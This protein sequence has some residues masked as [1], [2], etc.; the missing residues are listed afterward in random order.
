MGDLIEKVKECKSYSSVG[1]L[2]GYYYYNA[3]VKKN[4]IKF[5]NKHGIDIEKQISD[6]KNRKTYCLYCGKELHGENRLTRKFCNSSCAASYNNSL[7]PQKTEEERN[8]IS[9]GLIEFYKTHKRIVKTNS[10]IYKTEGK[11]ISDCIKDGLVLNPYD[12]SFKDKIICEK[13]YSEKTCIICGNKFKPFLNT[14][15]HLY[16]GNTCS[17]KCH[18]ILISQNGKKLY[19]KV[20]SEGR[21]KGW[22]SRNILSYPEMFWINVLINNNISFAPNKP[23]KKPDNS[24]YFL[25]FYIELDERKIDLEIDGKQHEYRDRVESDVK[26]DEY[27][28]S[29]GIEIYRVKWNEINTEKGKKLMKDKIDNFLTFINR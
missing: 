2:L 25:D 5:C 24:N 11:T 23:F 1:V 7:R 20:L 8:K 17:E 9:K 29:C 21:F 6:Y 22:Q 10:G 18:D 14:N 27:I 16:K 19:E 12:I 13:K 28:S 4:V 3:S 26:R 15:G